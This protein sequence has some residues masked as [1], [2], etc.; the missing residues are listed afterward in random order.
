M[1]VFP[2]GSLVVSKTIIS[3]TNSPEAIGPYSQAVNIKGGLT[4]TS[5]QIPL[6]KSGII[7]SNDFEEQVSQVLKN[8]QG[9]LKERNRDISDIIKLTVFIID[10]SNFKILNKI[11]EDFFKGHDFPS[12]SVVEVSKLPKNSQVE[13]EAIFSDV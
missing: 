9:I 7:I 11:F 12:R 2:F 10:L 1:L 8:I 3:T 5:G 13:I 4:F 6:N